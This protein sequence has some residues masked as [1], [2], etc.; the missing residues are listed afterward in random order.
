[1]EI[2]EIQNTNEKEDK[3]KNIKRKNLYKLNPNDFKEETYE[4][5]IEFNYC[6]NEG[7]T[8][9]TI[10]TGRVNVKVYESES[11]LEDE[12]Y[13]SKRNRKRKSKLHKKKEYDI[14]NIY[15][16]LSENSDKNFKKE[17]EKKDSIIFNIDG[18]NFLIKVTWHYSYISNN[19]EN[20]NITFSTICPNEKIVHWGV[21]KI[22]SPKNWLIPP[23][24]FLPSSTR[25][26]N[27]NKALE[28]KFPSSEKNGQRVI[29][30]VLPRKLNN[31][32]LGGIYFVIYDPIKNIWYNN[33]HRNFNIIFY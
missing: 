20:I 27:N 2:E 10:G 24:S 32:Y 14:N 7:I 12:K 29:S 18:K 8:K 21:Y 19:E 26:V 22:N 4:K 25:I 31:E 17:K 3:S 11:D 28:T 6:G 5:N 23:K 1:M 33:F 15:R 30:M 16:T 9:R 13:N